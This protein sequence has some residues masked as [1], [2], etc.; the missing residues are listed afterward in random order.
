[1]AGRRCRQ[2]NILMKVLI[3]AVEV[4]VTLLV[5]EGLDLL[6]DMATSED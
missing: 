1:M 4:V 6:R 3:G 2:V 5:A